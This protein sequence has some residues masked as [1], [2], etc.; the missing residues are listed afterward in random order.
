MDSKP[1]YQSKT[2]LLNLA[3]LLS[4][5][6]MLPEVG[7]LVPASAAKYVGARNAIV[8]LALRV[9]VTGGETLTFRK[10]TGQ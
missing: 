2:A 1:W 5:A 7:E 3:A 9:F 8:N 4:L 10:G 6:L